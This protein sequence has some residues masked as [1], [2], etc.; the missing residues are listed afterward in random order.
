MNWL[1]KHPLFECL[2]DFNLN[3]PENSFTVPALHRVPVFL[4]AAFLYTYADLV[5]VMGVRISADLLTKFIQTVVQSVKIFLQA[6]AQYYLNESASR[7]MIDCFLLSVVLNHP[8]FA[9]NYLCPLLLLR[10]HLNVHLEHV[11]VHRHHSF[12]K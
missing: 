12:F 8:L 7:P 9:C 6:L 10:K 5:F 2:H 1:G 3:E 4:L 11:I